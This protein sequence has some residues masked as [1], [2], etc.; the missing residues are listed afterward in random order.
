MAKIS[1][2]NWKR[3]TYLKVN[4]RKGKLFLNVN[5]SVS[6]KSLFLFIFLGKL[7]R[8]MITLVAPQDSATKTPLI[9]FMTPKLKR[10]SWLPTEHCLFWQQQSRAKQKVETLKIKSEMKTNNHHKISIKKL[11]FL[12]VLG[13]RLTFSRINRWRRTANCGVFSFEVSF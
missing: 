8:E 9:S 10:L 3:G 11:R 1:I 4:N 2:D 5:R 6:N 12:N 7:R 13:R